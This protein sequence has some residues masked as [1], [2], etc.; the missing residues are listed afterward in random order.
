VSGGERILMEHRSGGRGCQD[1]QATVAGWLQEGVP[2]ELS[3]EGRE[4]SLDIKVRGR[5]LFAEGTGKR[6]PLVQITKALKGG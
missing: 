1:T 6:L 4:T 3:K 2:L 5:G